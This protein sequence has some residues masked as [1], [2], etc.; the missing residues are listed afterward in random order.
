LAVK[1]L[2]LQFNKTS[3]NAKTLQFK[4]N[5]G[6]LLTNFCKTSDQ[7]KCGEGEKD[8]NLVPPPAGHVDATVMLGLFRRQ[9]AAIQVVFWCAAGGVWP[10][11]GDS[12]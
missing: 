5:S 12:P 9:S 2:F 8:A 1:T 10:E 11:L 6:F 3:L 4:N 7:H